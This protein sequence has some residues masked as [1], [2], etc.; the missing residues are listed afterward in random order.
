M[1]SILVSFILYFSQLKIVVIIR[2][3]LHLIHFTESV[4][5]SNKFIDA[6]TMNITADNKEKA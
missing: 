5:Y 1:F 4:Y 2:S 6:Y 3:V